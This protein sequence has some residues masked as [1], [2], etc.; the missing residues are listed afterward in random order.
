MRAILVSKTGGPEVLVASEVPEPTGGERDIIV[1]VQV[2]G[3]NFID[4][5][6]RQGIYSLALPYTPGLEGAG[7][8]RSVGSAVTEFS[9]GDRVAW[10]GHLGSYSEVVAMPADIAVLVPNSLSLET[11][12]GMMLQGLTAHY[13]VTSVHQVVP[14]DTALVHAAAGGVGL[15]LCQMIRAR[16]GEVIGT[17]STDAKADAALAAGAHHII[18]YDREDV[19]Q[20]VKEI[21]SDKGVRVVYDGVGRDTF[22]ASLHSL[23]PRGIM[24]LFG[25][26]SG[27]VGSFDPQILNQLGS[28]FLTRPSLTH[29]TQTPE[30]LRWRA[31]EVFEALEN[32]SLSFSLHGTYT[33]EDAKRAHEDL[34]ARVTSGKLLLAP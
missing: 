26:S 29:F 17:V 16:G 11:A 6:Q 33:L 4:I 5:Y 30:E 28:L 2:A 19:A 15:L 22:E 27:P 8:V 9:P 24:A 3:V 20:R 25:Q 23:A 10:T 13:L 21:T 18:R 1:D 14:G 32:G 7:V 31:S 12:A 34:A